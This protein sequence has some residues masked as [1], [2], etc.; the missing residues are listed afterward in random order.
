MAAFRDKEVAMNANVNVD[1]RLIRCPRCG[2]NLGLEY[3]PPPLGGWDVVCLQCG[4][5]RAQVASRNWNIAIPRAGFAGHPG[6]W[7]A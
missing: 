4:F 2:G 7:A 3:D 1:T 6:G 5:R